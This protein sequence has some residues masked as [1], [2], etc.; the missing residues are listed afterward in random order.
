MYLKEIHE[1]D[2]MMNET[3]K[4]SEYVECNNVALKE[5]V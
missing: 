4:V 5:L 3:K 2:K 1:N